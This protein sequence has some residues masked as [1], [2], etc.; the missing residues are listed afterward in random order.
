MI[1][2]GFLASLLIWGALSALSLKLTLFLYR[3]KVVSEKWLLLIPFLITSFIFFGVRYRYGEHFF[4]FEQIHH[5]FAIG[6]YRQVDFPAFL[7]CLPLFYVISI[8]RPEWVVR[9]W[10]NVPLLVFLPF[11]LKLALYLSGM[12]HW[13]PNP[14]SMQP[15]RVE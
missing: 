9:F 13:D 15:T 7:V 4:T 12:A 1:W 5:F 6:S 10:V 8:L 14:G 2:V 11:A 3:E